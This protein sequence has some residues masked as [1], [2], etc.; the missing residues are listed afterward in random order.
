MQSLPSAAGNCLPVMFSTA[1]VPSANGPQL[2]SWRVVVVQVEEIPAGDASGPECPRAEPNRQRPINLPEVAGNVRPALLAGGSPRAGLVNSVGPVG[3]SPHVEKTLEPLEHMVHTQ[4]DP[5]GQFFAVGTLSPSDCYPVGPVGPYVAGGPVGPDVYNTD[6][7]SLTHMVRIPPD[8]D[9]QD[10]AATGTPS[11]S[12]CY[13]AG[14]YVAEG[15]VG[16]DDCLPAL[17]SCEHLVLDHAD[18][19]GQHD[20]DLDTAE[21]LEYAVVENILDG[22]PME[23]ITCPELLEYSLRLLDVT[24]DGGLVK[25]ISEWTPVINPALSYTLDGQPMEGTTYPEH[26]ALGVSLDSRLTE[27]ASCLEP[28]EQSV[29]SSSLAVRPIEVSR[30]MF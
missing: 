5:A 3:P 12:D 30:R 4:T 26:L 24:L 10:A 18:P 25:R 9:G 23:G 1:P 27:G 17:E 13:P 7:N 20:T 6:P 16:P 8:L 21:S 11:P 15:P 29:R 2:G 19:V 28:L 14:P 22:R